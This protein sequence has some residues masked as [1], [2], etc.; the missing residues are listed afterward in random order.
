MAAAILIACVI[1]CPLVMGAMMLT[2]RGGTRR[3]SHDDESRNDG[4]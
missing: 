2:M 3:R 4:A 1:A